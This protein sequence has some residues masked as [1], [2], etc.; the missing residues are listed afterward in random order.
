[1]VETGLLYNF[2]LSDKKHENWVPTLAGELKRQKKGENTGRRK[3]Q[4]FSSS[5]PFKVAMILMM[6]MMITT[7]KS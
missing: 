3:P 5:N 2:F 4:N 6:M 7:P 1:M